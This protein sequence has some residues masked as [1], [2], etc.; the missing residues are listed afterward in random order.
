MRYLCNI[1]F[2]IAIENERIKRM[3][4]INDAILLLGSKVNSKNIPQIMK[5]F[6]KDQNV[7]VMQLVILSKSKVDKSAEIESKGKLFIESLDKN[8]IE[9]LSKLIGE[10]IVTKL[11]EASK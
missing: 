6:R 9:Q 2:I 5:I 1:S 10:D 4:K 8:Q 7:Q 11:V 3:S